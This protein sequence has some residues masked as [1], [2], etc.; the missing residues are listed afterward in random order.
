MSQAEERGHF[1]RVNVSTEEQPLLTLSENHSL[2]YKFKSI[3]EQVHES[4][5]FQLSVPAVAL[6]IFS[7]TTA[8]EVLR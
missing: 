6:R 3:V 4:R 2:A 7:G 1:I 8:L 5:D